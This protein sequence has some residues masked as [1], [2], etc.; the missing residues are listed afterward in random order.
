MIRR[1]SRYANRFAESP[2]RWTAA[3]LE[4]EQRWIFRIDDKGRRDLL[5]AVQKAY[6]PAKSLLYLN[7]TTL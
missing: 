3:E 2:A 7:L 6:D 4:A 1:A 5:A